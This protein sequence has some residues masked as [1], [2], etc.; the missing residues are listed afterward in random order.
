MCAGG[1]VS[2]AAVVAPELFRFNYIAAETRRAFGAFPP[3]W[4]LM[5][6]LAIAAGVPARLM[7]PALGVLTL[8]LVGALGARLD[9]PRV[10]GRAAALVGVSP[11]FIFNAASYFSH[12]LWRVGVPVRRAARDGADCRR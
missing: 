12:T 6:G 4:P 5:L 8:A 7:N 11:L 1:E 10:G 2:H 3:G 9:T